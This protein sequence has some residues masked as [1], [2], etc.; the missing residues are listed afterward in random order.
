MKSHRE[1][2]AYNF[3]RLRI[4]NDWTQEECAKRGGVGQ[5][6]ISQVESGKYKGFGIESEKKW[7]KIF[8]VDGDWTEFYRGTDQDVK[9][10]FTELVKGIDTETLKQLLELIKRLGRP[11]G[12][13]RRCA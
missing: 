12:G 13:I 10:E 7:A 6:Y 4:K 2:V 8:G 11:S 9:N 5:S 3:K 1:M